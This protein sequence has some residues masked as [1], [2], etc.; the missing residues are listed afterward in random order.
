MQARY[1]Y[2]TY[3]SLSAAEF[4]LEDCFASGEICEGECPDIESRKVMRQGKLV[5]R[6]FITLPFGY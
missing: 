2:A 5:T 4:G 1:D 3:K 6:Y